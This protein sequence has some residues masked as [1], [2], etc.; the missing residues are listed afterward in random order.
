MVVGQ[1]VE[2]ARDNHDPTPVSEQAHAQWWGAYRAVFRISPEVAQRPE[3]Q[4]FK[5]AGFTS[6]Y[7]PLIENEPDYRVRRS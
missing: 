2:N 7:F 3:V 5:G 6:F 4:R 1:T